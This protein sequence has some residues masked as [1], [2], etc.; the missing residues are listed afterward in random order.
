[1]G[2]LLQ[3]GEP[4]AVAIRRIA[5]EELGGVAQT[6]TDLTPQ[7][8]DGGIHSARKAF[9]RLRGL[10]RLVRRGL[11]E[12]AYQ[13]E[14]GCYRELARQL[15]EAREAAA[16]IEVF[17]RLMDRF[18]SEVAPGEF[19][20]CRKRMV[21]PNALANGER[22]SVAAM[23]DAVEQARVRVAGWAFSADGWEVLAP[24]LGRI[25]RVGLRDFALAQ[26]EP[27]T[28]RLHEWRKYV[29]YHWFHVRLL[30]DIWPAA[31]DARRQALDQLGELLGQEHDLSELRRR[32]LAG[33]PPLVDGTAARLC[34]L[35]ERQRAECVAAAFLAGR[36]L[37]AEEPSHLVSRLAAYYATWEAAPRC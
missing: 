18:A 19:D 16:V 7:S 36:R 32:V 23:V 33:E 37:Y 14:N 31:M 25:Y 1:M 27:T 17:D 34:G 24:G 35:I 22:A 26:S 9:K 21:E 15:A 2:F 28:Q 3:Y 12:P 6:L 8:L 20:E 30:K 29:K 4:V 10:V 5:D 11:G 13:C